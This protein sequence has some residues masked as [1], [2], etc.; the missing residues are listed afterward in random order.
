MLRVGLTGGIASG[1]SAVA[2]GLAHRGAVIIDADVL[3]REVV[4][5]RTPGLA[6]VVEHFG[7]GILSG[8][9]LDRRALGRL[10]FADPAARRDLEAIIHPA[11]RARAAELESA[12]GRTGVVVHV[13]PL[14]VETGQQDHFDVVVVVDVDPE[15]QLNRLVERDGFSEQEAVARIAAQMSRTERLAAADIVIDNRGSPT[16]LEQQIDDLWSKLSDTAGTG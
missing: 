12:P 16:D 2:A 9:G 7:P 10:V 4:A 5:P 15:T 6:A 3:A 14:L 8:D 1:K 13:I 11:V